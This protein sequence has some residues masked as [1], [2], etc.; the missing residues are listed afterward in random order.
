MSQTIFRSVLREIN[1]RL[2]NQS[3][4]WVVTGSFSFALRGVPIRPNDIDLQTD[5]RG[6]YKIERLCSSYVVLPVTWTESDR[7]RSHFGRLSIQ[8]VTVDVMGDLEKCL[9]NGE[10][11]D[12]PDLERHKRVILVDGMQIPVLSLAYEAAAYEK[13]GR[14]ARARQLRAWLG[15]NPARSLENAEGCSPPGATE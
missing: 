10:W 5:A 2:S 1:A 4:N 9:P 3:V 13:L 14:T 8:G 12:P 11:E 7:V 15:S 6:A